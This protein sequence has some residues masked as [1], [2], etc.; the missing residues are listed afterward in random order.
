MIN[1][2]LDIEPAVL[3]MMKNNSKI[4]IE[5][6]ADHVLSFQ[7]RAKYEIRW[8]FFAS[9]IHSKR[10][11]RM[12]EL[13]LFVSYFVVAGRNKNDLLRIIERVKCGVLMSDIQDCY[14]QL[15]WL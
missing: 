1:I 6:S 12:N 8:L 15:G 9:F 10:F 11:V 3:D 4:D 14:P 2:N 7:Y 13:T 5:E